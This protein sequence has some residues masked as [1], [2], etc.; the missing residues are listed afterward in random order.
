M[1]K[2]ILKVQTLK[3]AT[4]MLDDYCVAKEGLGVSVALTSLVVL[5]RVGLGPEI[6][7]RKGV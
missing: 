6:G 2:A 5:T 7:N 3:M 4:K 1:E